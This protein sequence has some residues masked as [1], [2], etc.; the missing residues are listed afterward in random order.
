MLTRSGTGPR[1]ARPPGPYPGKR[2]LDLG[3]L[4]LAAV[5]AALLAALAALAIWLDDGPPVLFRQVRAGRHGRPFVLLKLRTMRTDAELYGTFPDPARLTRVGRLLRRL[6]VDELPQLINVARG[7]MSLVG[8]RPTVVSQVRRYD[9]RQRGRL[10]VLPGL[11]GLAQVHGRNKLSWPE[12]IEW[13]LRYVANQTFRLD[14]AVLAATVRALLAGDGVTGHPHGDPIASPTDGGVHVPPGN[15]R[16]RL[17]K[18]DIGAAEIEAVGEVL[19]SGTL[20]AGPQ[21]AA[22]EREFAA[23]HGAGHAVTFAS[24]TSALA[25][26]LLAEGI[27]P[28]DEVIVPAMTFI[29]TATAVCHV[30]ATPVFADID[31]RSFNL[32]PAQIP[33][34]ATPRTRAVLA[35]HYGGQPCDL[36]ALLKA[37][38]DAGLVLLE[39]AAEAAGAEYR[40][41][42]VGTFGASAMFSLTPTKN[43]TT[44][45]GG[46]VL[47]G[48]ADT[49]ERLRMLRNHGQRRLYEHALIGYN[50]RLTE[51]QAAMGRVQLGKLDGILARKRA[52]AGWMDRRLAGVPGLTPPHRVRYGSHTY[53]LYTCLVETGRDAV[54][55]HLLDRGIEARVY[56]PPVHRQ[57][58]FAGRAARLPV[59]ESA[60]ARMLSIPMHSLLAQEE[61]TFI[62]D[63]LT[64]AVQ[65]A[66]ESR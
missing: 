16:V 36:A 26:M 51:M 13:D 38:A 44:G 56:F 10:R 58:I 23:R 41:Q 55:G 20:T 33:A 62:A 39:D 53:M 2:L 35:V 21:N 32:D 8:P 29:S 22:F 48:S 63:T 12:R 37:C 57:P 60:A 45:E 14:L 17:A 25:A 54:L 65:R 7:E 61:L 18:P 66:R 15:M 27:G 3:L 9:A 64:G 34:L 6:S 31:P 30:G 46:I 43:I 52:N 5:P 49:A 28:G 42:P 50:W 47:T 40:G 19:T 1:R 4:G 24:G 59:T 11:T